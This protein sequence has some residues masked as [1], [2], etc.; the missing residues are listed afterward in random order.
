MPSVEKR[1]VATKSKKVRKLRKDVMLKPTRGKSMGLYREGAQSKDVALVL[2]TTPMMVRKVIQRNHG[3]ESELPYWIRG[4]YYQFDLEEV[5]EWAAKYWRTQEDEIVKQSKPNRPVGDSGLVVGGVQLTAAQRSNLAAL[6]ARW[7]CDQDGV[8]QRVLNAPPI[9]LAVAL[10][11][12]C[13]Q[14]VVEL[15]IPREARKHLDQVCKF[16]GTTWAHEI[17]RA[18][19]AGDVVLRSLWRD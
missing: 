4:G 3:K 10:E 7:K 9:A 14:E 16:L 5:A 19:L 15:A 8:M 11:K 12:A 13:G 17:E 2:G 18:A 1:P 6:C